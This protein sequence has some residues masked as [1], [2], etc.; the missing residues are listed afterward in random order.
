MEE[1]ALTATKEMA[2]VLKMVAWEPGDE[3][4]CVE[5]YLRSKGHT[6]SAQSTEMQVY[7]VR[8]G[9][10]PPYNKALDQ[11]PCAFNH[12][13]TRVILLLFLNWIIDFIKNKEEIFVMSIAL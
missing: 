11:R 7:C 12:L 5:L 2:A 13:G 1:A 9:F 8:R 4:V 10:Y 6:L 3:V